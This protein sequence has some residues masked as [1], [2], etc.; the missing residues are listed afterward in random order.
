MHI[1]RGCYTINKLY[2]FI[3]TFY[4]CSYG[5]NSIIMSYTDKRKGCSKSVRITSEEISKMVEEIINS[6]NFN[7]VTEEGSVIDERKYKIVEDEPILMK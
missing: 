4:V 6:G 7:P 2:K 5:R 3:H 1:H